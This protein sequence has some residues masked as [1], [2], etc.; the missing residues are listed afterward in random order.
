MSL[1]S[2]HQ[3]TKWNSHSFDF[4]PVHFEQFP[5]LETRQIIC[6]RA[7]KSPLTFLSTILLAKVRRAVWRHL[8]CRLQDNNL[9]LSVASAHHSSICDALSYE[10]KLCVSLWGKEAFLRKV[11]QQLFPMT[12]L[13]FPE[14]MGKGTNGARQQ[15]RLCECFAG[16]FRYYLDCV[17]FSFWW[18][19]PGWSGTCLSYVGKKIRSAISF[20]CAF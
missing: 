11:T 4:P 18:W 1:T 9:F 8:S 19:S 7:T 16:K 3:S 15:K 2:E 13:S 20:T 17:S 10:T 6:I 12:L 5:L 14:E